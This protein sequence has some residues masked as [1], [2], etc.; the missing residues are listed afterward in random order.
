MSKQLVSLF[1]KT[2]QLSLLGEIADV[3]DSSVA[4]EVWRAHDSYLDAQW[5]D[6]HDEFLSW[7]ERASAQLNSFIQWSILEI[8]GVEQ[9]VSRPETP[10]IKLV[11][12]RS[13]AGCQLTSVGM[14]DDQAQR[15]AFLCVFYGKTIGAIAEDAYAAYIQAEMLGDREG[16]ENR[17]KQTE[18]KRQVV[19]E[20]LL[21][22]NLRIA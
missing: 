6:H 22:N 18:Q 12:F 19:V 4:A 14:S 15:F 17:R 8:Q 5:K 7:S 13:I 16:F 1:I 3:N 9:E 20:K 11:T 21:V 2:D 10:E